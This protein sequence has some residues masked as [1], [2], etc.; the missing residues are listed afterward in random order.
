M[1]DITLTVSAEE[2]T[3][4]FAILG[5]L[6]SKSNAWPLMMK[7]KSQ[8]ESQTQPAAIPMQVVRKDT[9]DLSDLRS[10]N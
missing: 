9:A 2:A 4:I 8:I 3:A 10:D 6:P 5:D 1:S 7:I